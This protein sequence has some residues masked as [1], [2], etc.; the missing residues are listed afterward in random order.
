[1]TGLNL[2][3]DAE[4]RRREQSRWR[5]VVEDLPVG[6]RFVFPGSI[7]LRW[8]VEQWMVLL[9]ALIEIIPDFAG[10]RSAI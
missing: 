6:W 9:V 10:E 3:V 8:L 4:S 5:S 1:M 2:R 7:S